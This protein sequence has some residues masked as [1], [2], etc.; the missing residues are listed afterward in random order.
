MSV[1]SKAGLIPLVLM[2]ILLIG[3]VGC[4]KA[5]QPASSGGGGGSTVTLSQPT[6]TPAAVTTGATSVVSVTATNSSSLPVAG[7][8]VTFAVSPSGA[9]TFTPSAATTDA[10]GV[11]S[12]VFT[13][14]ATGTHTLI[15]SATNANSK[16]STINVS[17]GQQSSGNVVV[18][19]APSLLT[20]DGASSATV[21]ITVDNDAGDPA[22][23][24]TVV[25]LTA[26]ERFVD[27]DGNGYFTNSVDSLT[28][29][30]NANNQWDPIGFIPAI[31]YTH[32]G[33]VSVTYTAGT[34]ATTTYIKA[35]V[36]GSGG[37][38]GFAEAAVQLTPDAAIYAIELAT[39]D[40][41]IQ[42]RHTG[43]IETTNLKAICYDVNGNT[44]PEGISIN[45]LI[46][47]GPDGGENIAGQGV[48]PV[49]ALT[50][51]RGVAT[52][53][54]WSGTI[55]GTLRLYANSGTVLSNATFVAVYA[56]PPYFIAIGAEKCNIP[57][58]NT[59]NMENKVVAV[60]SDVYHNP[61]QDSTVVYFTT[62]EGVIDAYAQ[63]RDTSGVATV[64]FR[65]GLPQDDGIVR[66]KAETSGGTVV[67]ST[68]FINSYIPAT[69]DVDMST[70]R[71][72]ANGN[73]EAI[74]WSDVRDLNGNYVIDGTIVKNKPL[75]GTAGT[76]AT[77]DGCNASVFEDTYKSPVLDQDYSMTGGTDNGI[78]AID[79]ITSR[80]GFVGQQVVCTLLTSTSFYLKSTIALN[81]TSIPYNATGV[82]IRVIIKDRYGNP[83]GD[84]TL[85]ASIS[86]GTMVGGTTTQK[87]N[88]F[89]E[90]FGFLFNAPAPPPP[91]STGKIPNTPALITV[92]DSD[93]LGSGLVLS[94]K[95]TYSA[96][97]KK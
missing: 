56:G 35:T 62:D 93:P 46:T 83:L 87:T 45:F 69:I 12:T 39:D 19:V 60:V 70:H 59:V 2:S 40:A 89:G 49:T 68:F 38:N 92:T 15:A 50:N 24:S 88:T 13:A 4:D 48:G 97:E 32:N 51:A 30:Y 53:P 81:S 11:A 80:S 67:E 16:Y 63:T 22:P 36:T 37:Y 8:Q 96:E 76:G 78:G 3:V 84:H 21:V 55:S 71:L 73:T 41:G 94:T 65:T 28:F 14:S 10:Y 9:G 1:K 7:L 33:A 75:F 20:A 82:P 27:V 77:K 29:D 74:I 86:A 47:D 54:I 42:V 31:A 23:E 79:V 64:A 72:L 34:E 25:K 91:D 43:G 61:V 52:V 57:G 90:A 5:A 66:I 6:A 44:V 58:W 95:I 85:A 17:S 26:G 18:E